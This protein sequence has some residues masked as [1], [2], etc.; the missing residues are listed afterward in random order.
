MKNHLIILWYKCKV[1][2]LFCCYE[3]VFS[4]SLLS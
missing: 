3:L 1:N 2:F 4:N